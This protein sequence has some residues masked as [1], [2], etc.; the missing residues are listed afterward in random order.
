MHPIKCYASIEEIKAVSVSL[1]S[2]CLPNIL[3]SKS[4]AHAAAGENKDVNPDGGVK[5]DTTNITFKLE[6]KRRLCTHL[7]RIGVI[8]AVTPLILGG[9]GGLGL[10]PGCTFSVNLTDPDF[11]L[12]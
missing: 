3:Q 7:T 11:S 5:N 1:L 8:E 10:V 2:R 4:R 9:A 6:I 12:R